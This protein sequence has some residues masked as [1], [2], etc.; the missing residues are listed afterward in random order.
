MLGHV[1]GAIAAGSCTALATDF[2]ADLVKTRHGTPAANPGNCFGRN[3]TPFQ[4]LVRAGM[5]AVTP[6]GGTARV[7]F[8][9]VG[10]GAAR[11]DAF[12]FVV[13]NQARTPRLFSEYA[14]TASPP[15]PRH[16]AAG[17][18]RPRHLAPT[19]SRAHGHK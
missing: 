8:F 3:G 10:I 7:T 12:I 5:S 18:P 15:T 9:R 14:L 4:R 11:V 1:L 13:V 2:L 16:L 6:L 17:P 19:R